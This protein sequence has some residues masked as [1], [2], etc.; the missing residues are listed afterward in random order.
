MANTSRSS[1]LYVIKDVRM[2]AACLYS[3][4]V[5]YL[6]QFSTSHESFEVS[7]RRIGM[8][9]T[10]VCGTCCVTDD[11]AYLVKSCTKRKHGPKKY[12]RGNDTKQEKVGRRFPYNHDNYDGEGTGRQGTETRS[13]RCVPVR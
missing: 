3:V 5:Y 9:Q 2:W 6:T 7:W 4:T 8:T 1:R 13:E 11:S 10:D 12:H